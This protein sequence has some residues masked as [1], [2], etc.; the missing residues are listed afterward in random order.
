MGRDIKEELRRRKIA[1]DWRE[2]KITPLIVR[3]LFHE[4]YERYVARTQLREVYEQYRDAWE[5]PTARLQKNV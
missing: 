4:A 2:L 1:R 3:T 5:Q